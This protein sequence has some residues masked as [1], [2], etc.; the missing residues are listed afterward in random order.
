MAPPAARWRW[1]RWRQPV[2]RTEPGAMYSHHW[3]PWSA[4]SDSNTCFDQRREVEKA[5]E[6]A[7]LAAGQRVQD[8]LPTSGRLLPGKIRGSMITRNFVSYEHLDPRDKRNW[9]VCGY[10]GCLRDPEGPPPAQPSL[11][12]QFYERWN[13]L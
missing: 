3:A 2:G 13:S 10:A 4:E 12:S 9:T 7:R 8:L 1:R 5:L 6:R 11:W